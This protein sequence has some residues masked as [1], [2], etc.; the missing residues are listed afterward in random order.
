MKHII[1]KSAT[2]GVRKSHMGYIKCA[3]NRFMV[4]RKPDK[5][6]KMRR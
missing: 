6:R 1:E 4:L 2:E 5:Q 3:I